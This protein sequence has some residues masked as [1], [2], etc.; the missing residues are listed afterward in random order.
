MTPQHRQVENIAPSIYTAAD[1]V[2][3]WQRYRNVMATIALCMVLCVH[4]RLLSVL[5]VFM[6]WLFV[7][8]AG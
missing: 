5:A 4:V 6:Y 1:S 3:A 2:A 8:F 7:C